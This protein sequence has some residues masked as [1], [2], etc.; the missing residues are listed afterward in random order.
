MFGK[1]FFTQ[2]KLLT[3][4]FVPT[5]RSKKHTRRC[6][7]RFKQTLQMT[8]DKFRDKLVLREFTSQVLVWEE[9]Y[10]SFPT[11]ILETQ[12]FSKM[13]RLSLLELPE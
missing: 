13:L 5:A 10:Q 3:V 2:T 4:M 11:L 7:N 1:T 12:I 8:L 6:G 9:D